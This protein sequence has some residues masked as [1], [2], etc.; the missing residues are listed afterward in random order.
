MNLIFKQNFPIKSN[1]YLLISVIPHSSNESYLNAT[2]LLVEDS[3]GE[4]IAPHLRKVIK[5]A[6]L[7][8]SDP[9]EFDYLFW[10]IYAISIECGFYYNDIN[11]KEDEPLPIVNFINYSFDFRK[12]ND[13]CDLP[14]NY[15]TANGQV[16]DIELC[17]R[18]SAFNGIKE[19]KFVCLKTT[20]ALVL[21]MICKY[22]IK[23]SFSAFL[24]VKDFIY[25]VNPIPVYKNL[26][27]LSMSLKNNIFLPARNFYFIEHPKRH[28]SLMGIP[29]EL[30]EH[31]MNL[32]SPRDEKNLQRVL[33]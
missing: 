2:I 4:R 19:F 29:Q 14:R 8:A 21:S 31:I 26:N 27:T 20:E 28:P 9:N 12:V 33:K 22:S 3:H 24:S 1:I 10:A 15:I 6:R 25:M 23:N 13:L 30:L 11:Q 7:N 17:I 18:G 16:Y 5:N 32:L